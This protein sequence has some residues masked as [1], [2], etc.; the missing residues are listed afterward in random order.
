MIADTTRVNINKDPILYY[1]LYM[2]EQLKTNITI[3]KYSQV[4]QNK[5]FLKSSQKYH[6]ET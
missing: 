3:I 1:F 2:N 6:I 4:E 5:L